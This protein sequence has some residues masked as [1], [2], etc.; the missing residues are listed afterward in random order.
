MYCG[1]CKYW[2]NHTDMW[3]KSWNT[4]EAAKWVDRDEKIGENEFAVYAD[5]ADDHGL[6]AGLKTGPMFGCIKFAAI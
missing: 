6:N 4:C 1:D 5:C 3:N 2:E